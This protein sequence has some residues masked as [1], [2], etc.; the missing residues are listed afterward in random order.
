[1]VTKSENNT[2]NYIDELI[3]L[4]SENKHYSPRPTLRIHKNGCDLVLENGVTIE[5]SKSGKEII[6][7][8]K[9]ELTK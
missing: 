2:K 6:K 8:L 3:K 9:G 4:I 7:A 5:R 1:M